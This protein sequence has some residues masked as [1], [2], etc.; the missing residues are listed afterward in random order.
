MLL[1]SL[2][3]AAFLAAAAWSGGAG[4]QPEAGCDTVILAEPSHT[5]GRSNTIRWEQVPSSCWENDDAAGK[6]STERRF[7]VTVTNTVTG[8]KD[9]VTVHGD[10]EVDATVD[11]D[12]FPGP[13]VDGQRFS[14]SIVR[15]ESVCIAGIPELGSCQDPRHVDAPL[16]E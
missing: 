13:A 8:A 10:G 11:P 3:A 4:A 7:V 14:Y 12:E 9:T 16:L 15:K 1:R 2:A 6:K 5:R